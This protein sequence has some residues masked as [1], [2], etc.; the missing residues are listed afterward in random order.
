MGIVSKKK[1]S[2]D[3]NSFA[4]L[5]W[6]S[7]LN[8]KKEIHEI[9]IWISWLKS[10]LRMVFLKEKSV[11]SFYVWLQIWNPDFPVERNVKFA[12]IS[13]DGRSET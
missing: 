11:F 5:F 7:Q 8:G 4:I 9:T 10:T 12:T 2:V 3:E 1:T 13:C 6:I